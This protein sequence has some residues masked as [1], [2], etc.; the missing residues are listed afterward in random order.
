MFRN[1]TVKGYS[2]VA[3]AVAIA[4]A[5]TTPQ[6][7]W[8]QEDVADEVTVT[9]SYIAR[10][11]DRPQPVA[12]MDA[13][14]MRAQQRVTLTEVVRDMPQVAS[15]NVVNNWQFATNSINLRGLGERS[16]LVLLNGQRMT[17]DANAGSQVDV[18]NLAPTIMVERMEMLLDGASALYGSD[19]VAGVANFITRNNFEGIEFNVSS[20]WAETQS[21][22]PEIVAGGIFGTGGEDS[23]LVMAFE[24]QRR[25]DKLQ[26][27]DR[28][29]AERLSYGL[30][31]ALWNPGSF[32]IAGGP[33][34]YPD[35]LCNNAAIGGTPAN[36]TSDPAGYFLPGPP[37]CRGNL[38]LQRTTVP[39]QTLMTGMAVY[40][41]DFEV[42]G[43]ERFAVEA[44]FARSEAKSSYGTGVPLLALPTVSGNPTVVS[45][46][47][48]TNPGVYDA[49]FRSGGTGTPSTGVFTNGTFRRRAHAEHLPRHGFARRRVRQQLV[50]LALQLELLAERPA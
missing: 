47:P 4:C 30:Q 42:G 9:G 23:N 12:V 38:A 14:E 2:K 25:E 16:T 31:T 18:N 8:A 5:A 44:G 43:L 48:A 17:I 49:W 19:A 35:P 24:M 39:E 21:D 7:I 10:P 15:A 34:W 27:E 3:A 32:N 22:V 33:A 29:D 45:I 41:K 11:A 36:E 50:R 37:F 6:S 20:Q 1:T 13:E 46:L 28:F 40:T 26:E